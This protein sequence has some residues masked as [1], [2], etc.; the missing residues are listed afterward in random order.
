LAFVALSAL[1]AARGQSQPFALSIA[2]PKGAITP[3]AACDVSVTLTNVSEKPIT[4]PVT[5][6]EGG[7]GPRRD[8]TVTVTS[9]PTGIALKPIPID[10]RRRFYT[11]HSSR[12]SKTLE[13]DQSIS[14]VIHLSELFDLSVPGTYQVHVRRDVPKEIRTGAVASNTIEITTALCGQP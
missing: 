5:N 4:L 3:G 2:G 7:W 9:V 13:P 10:P 6:G 14:G 11:A 1:A 8:L 12:R